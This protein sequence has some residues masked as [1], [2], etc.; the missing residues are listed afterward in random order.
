MAK[1]AK[2]FKMAK[3]RREIASAVKDIKEQVTEVANR[4]ERYR[5]RGGSSG[6]VIPPAATTG[7]T[8]DPLLSVLYG[9]QKIIGVDDARDKIIKKLREKDDVSKQQPKVLSIVGFGGLGKTTL[10]K[11]VYD[12][13]HKGFDCTAFVAM[14]RNPDVEKVLK[15]LLFEL[16]KDMYNTLNLEDLGVR[17]LIHQLRESLGTKRYTTHYH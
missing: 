17:E 5:G 15:G 6:G 12:E 14:S 13:L 4:D 1:M 16:D 9:N 8:I 2:L 11:A 3:A 7:T 10:A